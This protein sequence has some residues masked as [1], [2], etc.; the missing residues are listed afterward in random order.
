MSN[1][2]SLP[3]DQ[4]VFLVA[5]A[6]GIDPVTAGNALMGKRIKPRTRQALAHARTNLSVIQTELGAALDRIAGDA[7]TVTNANGV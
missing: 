6:A 7:A 5:G 1:Q 2:T 3:L 4:I